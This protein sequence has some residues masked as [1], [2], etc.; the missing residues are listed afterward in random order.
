MNDEVWLEIIYKLYKLIRRQEI[1]QDHPYWW[2]LLSLDG[3]NFHVNDLNAHEIFPEFKIMVIKE[4]D[5]LLPYYLTLV[6]ILGYNLPT[7]S[8]RRRILQH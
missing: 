2:V 4:E 5:I 6:S 8:M 1:I 3:F 7:L